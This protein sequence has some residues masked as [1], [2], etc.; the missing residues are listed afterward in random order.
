[1]IGE[2]GAPLPFRLLGTPVIGPFILGLEPPSPKQVRGLWARFGHDRVAP[3][4]VDV[5]LKV[6]QVPT[7]ARAWREILAASVGPFGTRPG[8]EVSN[9]ELGTLKC[10]VAFAW[11]DADPTIAWTVGRAIAERLGARFTRI[12]GG[13][14]MPW[15]NDARAV[16]DAIEPVMAPRAG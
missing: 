7:Y 8:L 2:V 12:P 16:A 5:M 14:H 4:M 10:P 15:T 1:M 6:E 9:A 3:E 13:G 11:G